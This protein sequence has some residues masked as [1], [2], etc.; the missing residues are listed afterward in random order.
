MQNRARVSRTVA[1]FL[2]IGLMSMAATLATAPVSPAN[3]QQAYV[4][5]QKDFVGKWKLSSAT[6]RP[7]LDMK[8]APTPSQEADATMFQETVTSF[9]STLDYLEITADG[10]YIFHRSGDPTAGP[11]A[12][13]GTW[14]FNESSLWLKLDTA[15]RLD[16]HAQGGEMQM[17]FTAETDATS[18]YAWLAFGWTRIK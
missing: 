15:P 4:P 17:T 2:A 3:A 12:R 6:S 18:K 5:A 14:S 8:N 9:Y 11:C 13:C 16:I 10:R 1:S 7:P